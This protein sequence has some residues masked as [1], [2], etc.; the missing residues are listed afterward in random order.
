MIS[1]LIFSLFAIIAIVMFVKNPTSTTSTGRK[2]VNVRSLVTSI[3][4]FILGLVLAIVQPYSLEKVDAGS[5]GLKVKLTGDNR[6]VSKSMYVSGWNIYNSYTENIYEYQ[7]T[8]Q[9]IEYP[10]QQVITKGGF[11]ATIHPTF[12]YSVIPGT[13]ADMFKN[14][15]LDLKTIEQAWLKNAITS[16]I[17][18]VANIWEVDSIFNHRAAFEA[19]IVTECNKRVSKWFVIS[20]LKTNIVPPPALQNAIEGKTRAIQEAQAALQRVTVAQAE[21]KEKIAKAKADSAQTVIQA[22]GEALATKLKQQTLT[23]LYIEYMRVN[24]WDG[25]NSKTVLGNG[26]STMVNVK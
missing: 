24:R 23:P 20:Q 11:G 9:T 26:T 21:G 3:G 2:E 15:R 1:G 10:E 8:Q 14:L 22:S 4:I 12:N 7:T 19:C 16:S 18:D 5:V 25:H 17:N 6:G 13:L